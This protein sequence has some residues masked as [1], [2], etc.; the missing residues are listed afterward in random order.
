MIASR[1]DIFSRHADDWSIASGIFMG[2]G[3]HA[4]RGYPW[5]RAHSCSLLF[6]LS[7]VKA[8]SELHLLLQGFNVG[9]HAPKKVRIHSPGHEDQHVLLEQSIPQAI[10]VRVP[11]DPLHPEVV[12]SIN[13]LESP[14][15]LGVSADT[16]LLGLS[17]RLDDN[18]SPSPVAQLVEKSQNK[19]EIEPVP[20]VASAVRTSSRYTP[21][22][23]ARA[24]L[25]RLR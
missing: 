22:R 24:I 11:S 2:R 9:P 19:P 13:V 10:I 15:D 7:K 5:S 16:R 23:I 12:F 21:R 25:R 20:E 3:W 4:D 17:I 14:A 6:D 8:G 18:S 1:S